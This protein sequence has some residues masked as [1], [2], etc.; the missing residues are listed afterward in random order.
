MHVVNTFLDSKQVFR[1]LPLLEHVLL[2]ICYIFTRSIDIF[3]CV[4]SV[5]VM[6]TVLNFVL[7]PCTT[8]QHKLCYSLC[9]RRVGGYAV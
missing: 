9:T 6:G 1:H 8:P 7:Q 3:G 4:V 2:S 5:L